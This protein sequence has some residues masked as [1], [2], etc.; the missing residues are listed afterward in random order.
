M[1]ATVFQC[2]HREVSTPYIHALGPVIVEYLQGIAG[3]KPDKDDEVAVVMEAVK[4]LELLVSLAEEA[5]RKF[6]SYY[7]IGI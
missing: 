3:N 6:I 7:V 4:L 2:P 1:L 5:H